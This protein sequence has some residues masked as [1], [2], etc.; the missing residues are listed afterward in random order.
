M[1][2]FPSL[3]EQLERCTM[4]NDSFRQ[5]IRTIANQLNNLLIERDYDEDIHTDMRSKL[6]HE[7]ERQKEEWKLKEDKLR[8]EYEELKVK[9]DA[10]S[11]A[12]DNARRNYA[13]MSQLAAKAD[14]DRLEL[15]RKL[16]NVSINN[17]NLADKLHI[18]RNNLEG[19]T[20]ELE[21]VCSERNKALEDKKRLEEEVELTR[22]LLKE[23][24]S[25]KEALNNLNILE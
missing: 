21:K 3:P 17:F 11:E 12:L 14:K 7:E 1:S 4:D 15:S 5:A 8:E 24:K 22:T 9:Y 13:K 19:A 25:F 16:D 2:I 18:A 10:M 6:W 20:K 23:L